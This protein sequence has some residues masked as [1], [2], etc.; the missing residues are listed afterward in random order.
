MKAA[1]SVSFQLHPRVVNSSVP[2]SL[3]S[4]HQ[5]NYTLSWPDPETHPL[6]IHAKATDAFR[7]LQTRYRQP[8]LLTSSVNTDAS[9]PTNEGVLLF[10]VIQA[11]QFGIKEEE[12]A[13]TML[14]RNVLP[15]ASTSTSETAAAFSEMKRESVHLDLTSGYFG[16]YKPYQDLIMK[17]RGVA[18]QVVAASPKVLFISSTLRS[19]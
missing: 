7:N 3:H 1:S 12:N 6:R 8:D 5:E 9:E 2:P 14:F 18:C 13:L 11:G 4:Y 15:A 17:C 10:P 19:H 16:L